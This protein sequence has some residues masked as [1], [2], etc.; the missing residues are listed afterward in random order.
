MKQNYL[1]NELKEL[2][3]GVD[4][5]S[6]DKAWEKMSDLLDKTAEGGNSGAVG[7]SLVFK[8]IIWLNSIFL[9]LTSAV[10]FAMYKN[11]ASENTAQNAPIDNSVVRVHLPP[12]APTE[13]KPSNNKLLASGTDSAQFLPNGIKQIQES[14]NNERVFSSDKSFPAFEQQNQSNPTE[15][16]GQFIIDI[17]HD[18]HK[19]LGDLSSPGVSKNDERSPVNDLEKTKLG[20]D[21]PAPK[22]AKQ[23]EQRV[24]DSLLVQN[25]EEIAGDSFVSD[26]GL[27]AYTGKRALFMAKSGIGVNANTPVSFLAKQMHF[28]FGC[29]I[30][31]TH[32]QALQVEVLYNPVAIKDQNWSELKEVSYVLYNNDITARKLN[33]LSIPLVVKHRF[34]PNFSLSTGVQQ[35]F[36]LGTVGDVNSEIQTPPGSALVTTYENIEAYSDEKRFETWNTALLVGLDYSFD[37]FEYSAR[38]QASMVDITANNFGDTGF[39]GFAN[40]NLSVAYFLVR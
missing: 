23:T 7:H 39:D 16:E 8:T 38:L 10:V 18:G 34:G 36:L 27:A 30:V 5:P 31:L 14:E 26:F 2:M 15:K 37:R 4:I 28:G 35:S 6:A 22:D 24:S 40:L 33:Y 13:T 1:N 25:E 11:D 20:E 3:E 32:R 9:V 21:I 29:E 17:D 19:S 12:Q